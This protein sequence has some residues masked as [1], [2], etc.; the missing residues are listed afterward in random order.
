MPVLGLSN[1]DVADVFE[2]V[3]DLLEVQHANPYRV[4]AYREG[5]RAVRT[6]DRSVFEILERGGP[7]QLEKLP[8]IGKSLAALFP[9]R[10]IKMRLESNTRIER[11]SLALSLT[12]EHCGSPAVDP[13]SLS[14]RRQRLH[15]GAPLVP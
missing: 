2:Q 9:L 6:L 11:R 12:F 14:S 7:K 13:G 3:A 10:R 15:S 5:A 1:Q 4:R 8:G